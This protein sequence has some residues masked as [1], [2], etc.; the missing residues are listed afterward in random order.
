MWREGVY[1]RPTPGTPAVTAEATVIPGPVPTRNSAMVS[2]YTRKRD[3]VAILGQDGDAL[4]FRVRMRTHRGYMR[5]P[6]VGLRGVFPAGGSRDTLVVRGTTDGQ[7]VTVEAERGGVVRR[8]SVTLGPDLGWTLLLFWDE[9]LSER[10]GALSALWTA[11]L[12]LPLAFW[13][14]CGVWGRRH[15]SALLWSGSMAILGLGVLPLL[16]SAPV[17]AAGGWVGAAAGIAAGHAL[18][19]WRRG[20]GA[21][22]WRRAAGGGASRGT[23]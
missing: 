7:R 14:A 23:P 16:A 22:G 2:V 17:S 20:A 8:S 10:S 9:H 4:Y 3:E 13:A 12:L 21:R 11:G 15:R 19:A 1:G 18:G 6:S 5:T